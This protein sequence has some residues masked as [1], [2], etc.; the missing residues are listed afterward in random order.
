MDHVGIPVIN[1]AP[2]AQRARQ[3]ARDLYGDAAVPQEFPLW[4]ASESFST[5]CRA[6]PGVLALLGI[7]NLE[8]GCGAEHHNERFDIDEDALDMGVQVTVGYVRS[9]MDH[10]LPV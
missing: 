3:V 1:S 9:L 7:Q 10:G 2:H 5:Y 8:K 4:Y 6:Y